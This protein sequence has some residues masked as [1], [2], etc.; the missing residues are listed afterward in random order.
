MVIKVSFIGELFAKVG[1]TAISVSLTDFAVLFF[2]LC[3]HI[4][5]GKVRKSRLDVC[6]N[7]NLN[8][9][10]RSCFGADFGSKQPKICDKTNCNLKILNQSILRFPVHKF[11]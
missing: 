6:F 3:Q 7:Q 9:G 4:Q 10:I 8:A 1:N 11:Q 2:V 5:V